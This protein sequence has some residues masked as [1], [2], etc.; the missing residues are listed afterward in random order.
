[1]TPTTVI[2]WM[3]WGKQVGKT[4][5]SH[6]M[7]SYSEVCDGSMAFAFMAAIVSSSLSIKSCKHQTRAL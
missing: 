7:A 6:C 4:C 3:S 2:M 5:S 1:M